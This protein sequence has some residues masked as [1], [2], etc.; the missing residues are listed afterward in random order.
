MVLDAREFRDQS[1]DHQA[2]AKTPKPAEKS[3]AQ[4]SDPEPVAEE[5]KLEALIEQASN[6]QHMR[7]RAEAICTLRQLVP[8]RKGIDLLCSIVEDKTDAR[9]LVA[10]QMLGHHRQWLSSNVEIERVVRWAQTE[11][12]PEVGAALV[13]ML[14]GKDGVEAFLLHGMI[15]MAREA[16]L[17][18]A[19]KAE[20]LPALV[21]AL[22]LARAPDI[23]RILLEKLSAIGAELVPQVIDLVLETDSL[24]D[25]EDL[26]ALF[27]SLPQAPLFEMFIAGLG[28]PKWDPNQSDDETARAKAWHQLAR[29]AERTLRR[30]PDADLIRYLVNRS[31]RDDTFARRH[32]AFLKA[33]AVNTDAVF[34][35]ELIADLERLTTGASEERLLRM[36][37]MLMDLTNK[38]EERSGSQAE[39]LLDEWKQTSPDLKLKIYH[40][41]Q[42]LQ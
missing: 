36:A 37:E 21:H 29:I 12:D 8:A 9:R 39:A 30:S 3:P 16:A 23:D 18:L 10:A 15:G 2:S 33:A 14:R 35:A 22:F 19:I 26:L 34:G 40:L 17:G 38:L 28:T 6:A 5:H 24:P 31:A 25:E 41:E 4:S 20:T 7:E 42:G 32:A 1:E 27:A 11:R 13:W